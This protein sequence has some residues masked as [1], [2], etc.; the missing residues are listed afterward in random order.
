MSVRVYQIKRFEEGSNSH[1]VARAERWELHECKE[2]FETEEKAKEF[3]RVATRGLAYL[4]NLIQQWRDTPVT[5]RTMSS[6]EEIV[7]QFCFT[8]DD[9]YLVH[10]KYHL[11]LPSVSEIKRKLQEQG[12]RVESI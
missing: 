11:A 5:D 1:A 6:V 9:L 7:E 3:I 8:R 12:V 4:S 2:F 10:R